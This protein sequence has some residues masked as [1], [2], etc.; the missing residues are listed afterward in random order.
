MI[1]I[2]GVLVMVMTLSMTTMLTIT[3]MQRT[4]TP[5]FLA[6][7]LLL[8]VSCGRARNLILWPLLWTMKVVLLKACLWWAGF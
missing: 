4:K 2:I 8:K 1:F 6:K 3:L 7:V 5:L